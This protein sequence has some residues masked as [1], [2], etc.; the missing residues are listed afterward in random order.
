[1]V[2]EKQVTRIVK[3]AFLLAPIGFVMSF[4]WIFKGIVWL[5]THV[6]IG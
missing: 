3:F 4:I 1:M 5:I 6:H 2:T